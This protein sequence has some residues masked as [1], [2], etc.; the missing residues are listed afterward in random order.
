MAEIY[1]EGLLNKLLEES[2]PKAHDAIDAE[3]SKNEFTLK[4]AKKIPYFSFNKDRNVAA[5]DKIYSLLERLI[6]DPGMGEMGWME[7]SSE[8][9]EHIEGF[10][11]QSW[12]P[13]DDYGKY[14]SGTEWKDIEEVGQP[15]ISDLLESLISPKQGADQPEFTIP[16][17]RGEDMN[18]SR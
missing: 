1:N 15:E 14:W 13:Y 8:L 7:T 5:S 12:G 10:D 11:N 2:Q 17:V 18:W 9:P 16:R 4:E 3:I 6:P